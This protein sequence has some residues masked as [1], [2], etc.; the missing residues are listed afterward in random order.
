MNPSRETNSVPTVSD[1]AFLQLQCE[2]D[3]RSP[4]M[5]GTYLL[6]PQDHNVFSSE[7]FTALGTRIVVSCCSTRDLEFRC[8]S[9]LHGVDSCKLGRGEPVLIRNC[10]CKMPDR[11]KGP[12]TRQH[13]ITEPSMISFQE[14]TMIAALKHGIFDGRQISCR[15]GRIK[16][17]TTYFEQ[18]VNLWCN[19]GNR[20]TRQGHGSF[21]A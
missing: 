8:D 17:Q 4:A 16:V 3:D 14:K 6:L 5:L 15:S 2:P 10:Q 21:A 20:I 11:I 18:T 13:P 9:G 7:A 12:R 19:S 1:T